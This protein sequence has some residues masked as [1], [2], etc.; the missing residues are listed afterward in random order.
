MSK[1]RFWAVLAAIFMLGGSPASSA[2]KEARIKAGPLEIHP[3]YGV[4]ATYDDNIYLVPRDE[5]GHAV[6]GG[7]VRGSWI[8]SNDA[9]LGLK[10]P[11]NNRH[12][13]SGGYGA[14]ADVYKTQSSA[15]NAITQS[16]SVSYGFKGSWTS[17]N[18]WD[19]YANTQDPQF[20]PNSAAVRG[21]LV[22]RQ[23]RWQNAAGVSAE[24]APGQ[25][26]FFGVD[27]QDT[28]HKYLDR[29]LGSNLNR[30]EVLFGIKSGYK[31]APKTRL[32]A[33]VHRQ[34]VHYSAGRAASHK[35]WL[36]DFGVEGQLSAKVRGQVQTGLEYRLYD[37]DNASPGQ[38]TQ[39]RNW[40]ALVRLDYKP[41]EPYTILLNITRALN[42]SSAN[43]SGGQYFISTGF[44]LDGT[45]Q[46]NKL[47]AGANVGAQFDKYAES[48]A[49][50]GLTANRRDDT[51]LIGAKADYKMRDWLSGGLSYQHMQRH[52]RFTRQFNYASNRV[53]FNVRAAF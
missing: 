32:Y 43:A 8:I 49:L 36:V 19:N 37:K 22:D 45:R 53:A 10:L 48:A 25:K 1:K 33:A 6:A 29:T 21:E 2:E 13:F 30:S 9:A 39:T 31:V 26:L 7:G 24:V 17:A 35:D 50:G 40:K 46:W 20:N 27:A 41:S 12:S 44:G 23:R 16:V 28:V 34:L 3:S 18:V 47:A 14:R 5:S 15:N 38:G 52:S 51:Y 11:L 4:T 42:E